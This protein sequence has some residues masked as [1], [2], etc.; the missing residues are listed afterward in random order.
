MKQDNFN[1][2][3]KK[4]II[5]NGEI[6]HLSFK[7]CKYNIKDSDYDE[8]YRKYYESLINGEKLYIIEKINEN[9]KFCFFLDIEIPKKKIGEFKIENADIK[10]ILYITNKTIEKIYIE[11][12][13]CDITEYIISKRNDKYHV[14]YPNLILN[15]KDVKILIKEIFEELDDNMKIL[16]DISVYRTGLRLFGSR[17]SDIEVQNES[18]LLKDINYTPIYKIY[19]LEES[20]E[21]SLSELT[22][23]KFMKMVIRKKNVVEI[24][25]IKKEFIKEDNVTSINNN[26]NINTEINHLIKEIKE[27]NDI[28]IYNL[29]ILKI[30]NKINK[31]GENCFYINIKDKYCPFYK[32]EHKRDSNPLYIEISS[33]G[34]YMKCYN[35]ECLKLRYPEQGFY[36]CSDNY[37]YIYNELKRTITNEM[38]LNNSLIALL[39][40]S[41]N[42]SHYKIAKVVYEIY[43]KKYRIDDIKNADWYAFDGI[44]WKRSYMMNIVLSEEL[45]KYYNSIKVNNV[46]ME[47]DELG[48]SK[49]D[50]INKII[51]KLENVNFKKSI[52]TEM[53]YLFK[54]LELNFIEKLDANPYLLGFNNGVY[55]LKNN[56]FRNGNLE[57]YLTLTTGYDYIEYDEDDINMLELNEFLKKIITNQEIREYLLKILGRSLLGI[58]D[59][60]FYIFSGLSGANGKSTL[61]NLLEYTLGQYNASADVSL[62]TNKRGLSGSASP[63]IIRLKGKRQITFSE[64][65]YKDELKTGLIKVFSGGDTII[66]RELY[67][68]PISFKLQ[69]SLFMCCNDLPAISSHDGGTFRRLR[70]IEFNSRFCDN[71]QKKNEFKIDSSIKYKI[72]N[73]A[74]YFMNIL[75]KYYKIYLEE[76]EKYGS[77]LE[78]DEV[79]IAT[80]KYKADND[81]FNEYMTEN[82]KENSNSFE[83]LRNIYNDF[84]RWWNT[85]YQNKKIPDIKE[86]RKSLKIKYGEEQEQEINNIKQ[87]GFN[88]ILKNEEI[89]NEDIL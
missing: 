89:S 64:P 19:N 60:K 68:P 5:N 74:P 33:K 88:I 3:V 16:I 42:G 20:K 22:Y 30:T 18:E 53:H 36:H 59:E 52:M 9:N 32:R 85:N 28:E 58:N 57:D 71:P 61:I 82:I 81:R 2:Y 34:I 67:K 80:S 73:W 1:S 26:N 63:D 49:N 27:K 65:E 25:K 41:L 10:E 11:N 39:E 50:L 45:K 43:K 38:N 47:L 72:K 83:T 6:S 75:I 66:A 69:A 29:E 56:I 51:L 31:I 14:N 77:I 17:K 37:K 7:K 76:V 21:E 13:D 40:E 4:F 70:V 87:I 46:D 55:D 8:F 78:P 62:I 86:L 79:K 35:E 44:R 48:A 23:E 15:M 84:M 12:D 54:N 24:N